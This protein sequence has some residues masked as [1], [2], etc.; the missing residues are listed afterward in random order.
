MKER[1]EEVCEVE[2]DK[3]GGWCG[4]R[5]RGERRDV[6]RRKNRSVEGKVG[7]NDREKRRDERSVR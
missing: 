3:E 5:R 1:R 4:V 7:M 6:L 2:K